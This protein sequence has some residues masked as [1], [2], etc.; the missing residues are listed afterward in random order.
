MSCGF[1][2]KLSNVHRKT[3]TR[4]PCWECAEDMEDDLL[5]K[6]DYAWNKTDNGQIRHILPRP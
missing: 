2:L 5:D 3:S 1:A 4:K 6:Y